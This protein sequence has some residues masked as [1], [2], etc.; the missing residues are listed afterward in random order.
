MKVAADHFVHPSMLETNPPKTEDAELSGPKAVPA[1]VR[2]CRGLAT[3]SLQ[4]GYE[5]MD[6]DRVEGIGKQVM[7]SVKEAI[8]KVTGD[9]KIHAE[10]TAEKAAGKAQNVVGG[11]KD[12]ARDALK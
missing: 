12:A 11:T 7:G 3:A 1:V 8:G 4:Q 5:A 10:G 2:G 6:K 9:A